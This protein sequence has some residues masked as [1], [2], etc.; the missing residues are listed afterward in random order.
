M[1]KLSKRNDALQ[2]T[3]T[4]FSSCYDRC[5]KRCNGHGTAQEEIYKGLRRQ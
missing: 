2:T 3:V 1:K 4:T 5:V